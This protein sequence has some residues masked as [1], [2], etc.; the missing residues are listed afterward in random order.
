M[1]VSTINWLAVVAAAVA[2][3]VVGGLWYSPLLFSN[4][5][6]KENNLSA[7][8][9]G[10]SNRARTFGWAFVFT[11][12]MAVNLALFLNDAN[13][14]TSWGFAAGFLAGIWVFAGLAITG[15]FELKSWKYIFINGGY[16]VLAL[17]IMGGII[18]GWR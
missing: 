13:T 11:L 15:L 9:I 4:A 6:M 14:D 2:A 16:Q 3:F 5:W 7:E 17:T 12:M 8:H 10:R 18:G 1:D